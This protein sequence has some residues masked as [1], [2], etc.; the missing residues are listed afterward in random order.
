MRK[1]LKTVIPEL[2][3]FFPFVL[4]LVSFLSIRGP[5]LV[6]ILHL[7]ALKSKTRSQG[8]RFKPRWLWIFFRNKT[9]EN[10]VFVGNP[11][12]MWL[13]CS[14]QS[15][16][17]QLSDLW[18]SP[19][20]WFCTSV[21]AVKQDN[22]TK[23]TLILHSCTFSVMVESWLVVEKFWVPAR[24]P[25]F[26]F[27]NFQHFSYRKPLHMHDGKSLLVAIVVKSALLV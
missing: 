5:L 25:H 12:C 23:L 21:L 2:L 26:F 22:H 8:R 19:D 6:L 7:E 4:F 9:D 10:I 18:S 15:V 27:I 3:D 14:F 24:F 16:Y 13:P 1:A 11:W 20:S 17:L